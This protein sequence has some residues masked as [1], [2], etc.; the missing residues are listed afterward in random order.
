MEARQE[1]DALRGDTEAGDQTGDQR[2]PRPH[3]RVETRQPSA[4]SQRSCMLC[5]PVHRARVPGEGP[6][7]RRL[8]GA[9]GGEFLCLV[10]LGAEAH[11]KPSSE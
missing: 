5:R 4:V 3:S 7:G 1:S 8:A 2:P 9:R 6:T 11:F 10:R